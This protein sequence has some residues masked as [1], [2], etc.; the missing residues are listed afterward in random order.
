MASGRYNQKN[1][2]ELYGLSSQT[3]IPKW[4]RPEEIRR[5]AALMREN[6]QL[7]F[8]EAICYVLKDHADPSNRVSA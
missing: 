3:A 7:T 2:S 5:A 4:L 1:V 6:S 8:E